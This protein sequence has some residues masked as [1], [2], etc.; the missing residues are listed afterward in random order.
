MTLLKGFISMT[1]LKGF[2]RNCRIEKPV[3]FSSESGEGAS[4]G[5]RKRGAGHAISFQSKN[6]CFN[7]ISFHMKGQNCVSMPFDFILEV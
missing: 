6:L 7:P 5:Q 4:E 1:L 3:S 2:R